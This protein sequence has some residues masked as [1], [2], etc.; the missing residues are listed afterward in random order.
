MRSATA[1]RAR[2]VRSLRPTNERQRA[3]WWWAGVALCCLAGLLLRAWNLDFDDRQHLHPDERHW[4]LTSAALEREPRPAEHGTIVGPLLDWLDGE[5]SPANPYR[6][7]TTFVYGPAT[8]AVTR[9]VAGWLHD[10][11]AGGDQPAAFVVDAIDALGVPL[12]DDTGAPR[13]DAGYGVDLV[14]RLLGALTDTATIAVVALIGRRVGGRRVGLAA[15]F[16]YA[17]L[18]LALQHAHF[19]GSEPV[20][21]LT[22]ALTVMATLHMDRGPDVRGAVRTGVVA[23]LAAGATLAA[24]MTGVGLALVPIA[25]CAVLAVKNRRRA[26]V[27]RLGALA[28]GAFV[29]FR[30]LCPPAFNGLGLLP[31]KHFFDDLRAQ[32]R[33]AAADLPPNLQWADRARFY[34][35]TRWLLEF[36]IGPGAFI[37][38][39]IGAVVLVRRRR[40]GHWAPLVLVGAFV[41]PWAF[42]MRDDVT[43][44]RYFVPMLP[45]V[46]LCAGYALAWL[47]RLGQTA[48]FGVLVGLAALWPVAF[49]AGVHGDDHTRVAASHWIADH[50]EQGAVL[51]VESWDDGL[52]LSIQGVDRLRYE[53]EQLEL[54]GPDDIAKVERLAEQLERTPAWRRRDRAELRADLARAGRDLG[55][56]RAELRSARGDLDQVGPGDDVGERAQRLG[57]QL[58]RVEERLAPWRGSVDPDRAHG[59]EDRSRNAPGRGL[60]RER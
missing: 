28:V 45:G 58:E 32:R 60:G 43:S 7:T 31:H 30:V 34:D 53:Y 18:V 38:A 27:A 56:H 37:A 17:G 49:V 52:P 23:G 41:V 51:S 16:I 55:H 4:S 22:S 29:A 42:V 57:A 6:V 44:G 13:F 5:R 36:T 50:V 26:D 54:W 47:W 19:L 21:A 33:Y 15:A 35:G 12:L 46:A 25:L 40:R 10:G 14:G 2:S 20:L 1:V 11:A 9:G 39:V 59:I 48:V 8:L 3:A 24:K